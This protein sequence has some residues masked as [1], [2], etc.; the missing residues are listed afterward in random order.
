MWRKEG[1]RHRS[2]PRK[3]GEQGTRE[4]M[5]QEGGRESQLH[6]CWDPECEEMDSVG[7][8]IAEGSPLPLTCEMGLN[9]ETQ[10]WA[11]WYGSEVSARLNQGSESSRQM[12]SWSVSTRQVFVPERIDSWRER[13]RIFRNSWMGNLFQVS[14]ELIYIG[15][16]ADATDSMF[17]QR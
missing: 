9:V 4:G 6:R 15:T 16:L 3:K 5:P 10:R 14:R 12:T 2:V 11:E 1:R 7:S 17:A 8:V 13:G